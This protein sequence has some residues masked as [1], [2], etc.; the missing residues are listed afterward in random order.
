VKPTATAADIAWDALLELAREALPAV[1]VLDGPR[2]GEE[3]SDDVLMVGYSDGQTPALMVDAN[4][5][6]DMG[7]RRR[8]EGD[9]VCVLSCWSGDRDLA[10]RRRRLRELYGALDQAL[11]DK[12]GIG[13]RV[14]G[15]WIGEEAAWTPRQTKDGST[16][17]ASFTVHYVAE[18]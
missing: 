4:I 2:A 15:G 17:D 8:E 12:P 18:I 13:G 6:R 14:D 3:L 5:H 7:A 11:R 9:I 16:M 1:Q 10:G